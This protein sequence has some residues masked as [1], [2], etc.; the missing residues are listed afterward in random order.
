MNKKIA[1]I[2]AVIIILL[3]SS[4]VGVIV[5]SISLR[6]DKFDKFDEQEIEEIGEA[7]SSDYYNNLREKYCNVEG[8]S[9]SEKNCCLGSIGTMEKYGYK[10]LEGD[11]CPEGY[12]GVVAACSGAIPF[13]VPP[14]EPITRVEDCFKLKDKG[15]FFEPEV[16]SNIPGQ[17]I[18][19]N[20]ETRKV[21]SCIFYFVNE[22]EEIIDDNVCE[23]I[24]SPYYK[25]LCK[26]RIV[27][28][29]EDPSLCTIEYLGKQN[30]VDGCFNVLSVRLKD[31]SL[32]DKSSEPNVCYSNYYKRYP[33]ELPDPDPH[34]EPIYP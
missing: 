3:C 4:I 8:L 33:E 32:C 22:H 25:Y 23:K 11:S 6:L 9:G 29:L 1:F 34:T 30:N 13:C 2:A 21:D 7:E 12:Q 26:Q 20:E 27:F 16:Y 28:H 18:E 10:V 5:V 17:E 19:I 15:S 31:F 24:K 14:P